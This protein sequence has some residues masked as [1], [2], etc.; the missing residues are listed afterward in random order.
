MSSFK[1][2]DLYR[3]FAAV[4]CLS[5]A[6]NPILSPPP[7]HCIMY[8]SLQSPYF[9]MFMGPRNWFQGMN[10]A[11]LCCL[12]GQYENPIPPRFLAPIDF[13]KI[14][15]QYTYSH[16]E[17]ARAGLGTRGKVRGVLVHKL[18]RKYQHDW[19]YL[20]SINS[21]IHLPR[22]PFIGFLDDDILLW[23]LYS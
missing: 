14:P 15:A 16:R 13:L 11:S 22:S 7:T 9:E 2:I 18:G 4:V 8:T 20:Q 23:C 1:K 17:G 12:A 6:Q 19:L 3:D 21:D 10:S 5:E